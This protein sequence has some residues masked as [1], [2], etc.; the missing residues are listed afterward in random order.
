MQTGKAVM[1]C[2][3]NSNK[4]VTW[5]WD[6]PDPFI[7]HKNPAKIRLD[8]KSYH[9]F[10]IFTSGLTMNLLGPSNKNLFSLS[11]MNLKDFKPRFKYH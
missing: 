11:H 2:G 5:P 1:W 3:I 8:E 9:E 6:P 4:F 10:I 7:T